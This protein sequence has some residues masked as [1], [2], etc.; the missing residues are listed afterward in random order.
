[1]AVRHPDLDRKLVVASSTYKGE[2]MYDEVNGMKDF[3]TPEIFANTPIEEEYN[4]LEPR[5][6]DFP[7]LVEKMN[8]MGS[9]KLDWTSLLKSIKVPVL[10]VIGDYFYSQ[11]SL[12]GIFL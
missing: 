2:G 12:T 5:P 11:Y 9:V 3:I 8:A 6:E 4:K 7:E 10:T 1:M